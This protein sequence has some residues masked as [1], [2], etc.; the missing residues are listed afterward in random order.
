MPVS[1][2]SKCKKNLPWTSNRWPVRAH[3]VCE[4]KFEIWIEFDHSSGN[5]EG[6]SGRHLL[7]YMDAK[8]RDGAPE[9]L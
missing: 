4:L 6:E 5:C 8:C 3:G 2:T 7:H 9:T 1:D